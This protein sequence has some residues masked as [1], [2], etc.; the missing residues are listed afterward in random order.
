MTER[1]LDYDMIVVGSGIAGLY[2]ALEAPGRVLVV[3]KSGIEEAS[4]RYAQGG[5]AAAVGPGDDPSLHFQDT[6]EAGAGLVNEEAARILCFEAADRVADLVRYGVRFDTADGE[7]ELGREAAHSKARILHARGDATGLEIELSLSGLAR[8]RGTVL[9][10]ALASRIVT[11]GGRARGVEVFLHEEG[12]HEVYRAPVVVLATGGAGRMY[13]TTTNPPVSTG[14]GVAL[15]YDAGAEVMDMEFTQ[16]HPTA[17]VLPGQPVFLI[18]EAVRGEG[19]LLYNTRGERFMPR[20][21]PERVELAPRDV[22]ARATL[23]EMLET[24]SDHVLLDATAR[25][26][27]W[28]AA[29]FPKIYGTC[30]EAGLDMAKDRLPVSPAAHYSMGGVRTNTWGETTVPGLF[31]VGEVACTGVHG[32]N[33]LASNS[34]LETVVFAHRAVQRLVDPPSPVPDAPAPTPDALSLSEVEDGASTSTTDEVRALMWRDV[35]IVRDGEGLARAAAQLGI[36]AA[37]VTTPRDREGYELRSILTCARL[38]TEAALLRAESRGAHFRADH[39][40]A[41]EAWRKHIVFR[42]GVGPGV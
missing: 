39:P 33:R 7:V 14:D 30:L 42:G 26:A 1:R 35:G 12:R 5:I 8:D 32:A 9:E 31:A 37:G 6:V 27:A 11:E 15:A 34:L 41:V 13:R 38:A 19:A 18:S 21:D 3:T 20:Y 16:F 29:R 36:W 22:V 2:A 25:D 4:T 10:H 23:R 40:S 28:L 24:E 17:L